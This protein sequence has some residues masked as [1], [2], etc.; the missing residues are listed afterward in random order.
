MK[1]I[2]PSTPSVRVVVGGTWQGGLHDR[3][4]STFSITGGL[5]RFVL[6]ELSIHNCSPRQ[7]TL[8]RLNAYHWLSWTVGVCTNLEN[9]SYYFT[10]VLSEVATVS[11]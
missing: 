7:N 1:C 10:E 5:P 8:V 6:G 11:S 9:L 3:P 4:S 2:L